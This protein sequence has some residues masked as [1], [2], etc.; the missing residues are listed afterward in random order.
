LPAWGEAS[1]AAAAADFDRDGDLDLAIGSRF[2]PAHY[3][4][5]GGARL[6]ANDGSGKFTDETKSRC[7]ALAD[8]GCVASAMWLDVDQN[9]W[10]D[11]VLGT[12]WGPVRLYLNRGG[13]LVE[14]TEEWKLA[15][16]PGFW[17]GLAAA[18]FDGDGD[19]DVL[20]A[21]YGQ[22]AR[23]Y[24]NNGSGT[25]SAG[26]A[27]G[28]ATRQVNAAAVGDLDNDGDIDIV[29][30]ASG[31]TA[32]LGQ[33]ET[34]LNNGTGTSFNAN[35]FGT[36]TDPSTAVALGDIDGDGDLD[37]LVGMAST[38]ASLAY[39]NGGNGSLTLTHTF[40]GFNS[41]TC[42]MLFD[43]DGDGDMDAALGSSTQADAVFLGDGAG[44][45]GAARTFGGTNT[46]AMDFVDADADGDLDIVV[47]IG[48][49]SFANRIH[50][51]EIGSQSLVHTASPSM[52]HEAIGMVTVSVARVGST[53][54]MVSV[55][56]ATND[57][58]AT[59]GVDY[60]GTNGSLMWGHGDGAAKTF[61]I[62]IAEDAAVEAN[63]T[64][65]IV[66][67]NASGASISSSTIVLTILDNDTMPTVA[68]AQAT[69]DVNEDVGNAAI[70]VS[71]SNPYQQVVSVAY[72][73]G[74][75]SA[76]A[77]VDYTAVNGTLTFQPGET[78]KSFDIAISDDA[79]QESSETVTLT[80]SGPSN[81]TLGAITNAVLTILDN[82][83]MGLTLSYD[84]ASIT[85][86]EDA[87][88]A[89]VT[90]ELNQAPG[91]TVTVDYATSNGTASA[92]NDYT[93]SSG[94]L[95]FMASETSKS[96]T[97]DI[98]DD[99]LDEDDETITVTL[100]NAMGASLPGTATATVTIIDDDDSPTVGV[101]MT[102]LSV[103]EDAGSVSVTVSLSTA[104]G[105]AVVVNYATAD[106][107]ASAG[108][109]YTSTS[110]TLNFAAGETSKVVMIS[111]TDDSA[112]EDA[113]SFALNLSGAGNATI[114]SS[115]ATITINDN[116]A[117]PSVGFAMTTASIDE[118]MS[119][120]SL[121]V[122]LSAASGKTI[123][124]D[125][126][127]SNGSATAGSDYS[128]A[129]GTLT[130]N[131][132][133]SSKTIDLVVLDDN[134]DESDET[135]L[136]TLSNPTQATLG[137]N[138]MVTATIVDDEDTP[139]VA[140]T[141][142]THTVAENAG[143]M[144][145]DVAL[146][147]TSAAALSVNFA[148]LP[149]SASA[150]LDFVNHSGTLNFAAGETQ[151][152]ITMMIV[153]NMIYEASEDFTIVLSFPSAGLLLGTNS[154]A[155]ITITDDEAQP[156][157]SFASATPSVTEDAT[158]LAITLNLSGATQANVGF[159]FTAM[160][161]SASSPEDFDAISAQ[162]G[163]IVAGNTSVN[164]MVAIKEDLLDEDDETITLT[165]G[166]ITIAA[167]GTV[168][169]TLTILD[170][171]AMPSVAF[172]ASSMSGNEDA[173]TIT[174]KALL[175]SAS[176]RSVMVDYASSDSSAIAP[177]DYDA[178]NGTLTFNAGVTEQDIVLTINDDA[179][180]EGSESF[181]VTLT[182]PVNATLGSNIVSTLTILDDESPPELVFGQ[183]MPN[184]FENAGM[185][186]V[187]VKLSKASG[188]TVMVD[189][190]TSDGSALAAGDY[191][192]QS[193]T[194]TFMPN[195]TSKI[196]SIALIDD[197][198]VE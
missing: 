4:L 82:D 115:N 8:A 193:G 15:G 107:T 161:G 44:S 3:P 133:E 144:T 152:T 69:T 121:T 119:P 9:G 154:T 170:D 127:S 186:D 113:E 26:A 149:G 85:V 196:V 192:A 118:D 77:G 134:A 76:T 20:A 90:V 116:D 34:Y 7:P 13:K 31:N 142:V 73:S 160:A 10:P 88:T 184:A 140:F 42:V 49:A 173:G 157:L 19:L 65:N 163:T 197:L 61:T 130:F 71:L 11:L 52:A 91:T 168:A 179:L 17:F 97:I 158:N 150:T 104:S 14:A 122:T 102:T 84:S 171:D 21:Y 35:A 162:A 176:G 136:V 112:D 29:L 63:E 74:G 83:A 92:G 5:S 195:E 188:L 93:A 98:S 39:L 190:A 32:A 139:E 156:T 137:A 185:L 169:A 101:A 167:A 123:T 67:S 55:D 99:S 23:V 143:M 51:N 172:M 114:G 50:F 22:Q 89:T 125:Y 46:R 96:F 117:A 141:M 54:G 45:F 187:E 164:V 132:G 56:Y 181:F 24:T 38:T 129:T 2:T 75:G 191:T 177:A 78:S 87:M 36:G 86:D 108:T 106:G 105:R 111:I 12:E 64:I 59:N 16:L 148:A 94:T 194:L 110:N 62:A 103:A 81:A 138:T 33:N 198:L 95:T 183:A 53:T 43:A 166:N 153:D 159:E 80:I 37:V 25:F 68:F 30:V 128:A 70:Q 180:I 48:S 58:T 182:N 189:F 155:T 146:T 100:S 27:V 6:L 135:F 79:Q 28:T 1:G 18:D 66:L 178:A 147:T 131:A 120:L 60:T 145:V 165:L 72:A 57:G 151:K 126:A 175:S 41:T 109:D 174:I 40:T 47:G 124:V